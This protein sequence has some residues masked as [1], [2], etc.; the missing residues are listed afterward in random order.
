[1]HPPVSHPVTNELVELSQ[2]H[3][4]RCNVS[5]HLASSGSCPL[6]PYKNPEYLKALVRRV[7]QQQEFEEQWEGQDHQDEGDDPDVQQY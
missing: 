1:M 2:L 4:S 3:C 6:S 7:E 5:G